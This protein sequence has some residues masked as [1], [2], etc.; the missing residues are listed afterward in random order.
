MWEITNG[1]KLD[2]DQE[3]AAQFALSRPRGGCGLWLET[4]MG[5]GFI[6]AWC[7]VEW[8][9]QK[10]ITRVLV[11][12]PA[13]L[14]ADWKMK[15]RLYANLDAYEWDD[16]PQ[17]IAAV[18]IIS[19]NLLQEPKRGAKTNRRNRVPEIVEWCPQVVIVDEAHKMKSYKAA[20]TKGLTKI[21]HACGPIKRLALT[22]TPTTT[23]DPEELRPQLTFI[24]ETLLENFGVNDWHS[25]RVRFSDVKKQRFGQVVIDQ[26]VGVK[27]QP[28]L[29]RILSEVTLKQDASSLK[30]ESRFTETFFG[31]S[32]KAQRLYQK[33]IVDGAILTKEMEIV[34]ANPLD[35]ALK[36]AEIRS[37]FIKDFAGKIHDIDTK[38]IDTVVELVS[39]TPL[40]V[41]VTYNFRHTGDRLEVALSKYRVGHIR[42]G[43]SAD[44]KSRI[45]QDFQAGKYD[46]VLGQHDAICLGLTFT[47]G[48]HIIIAE[49]TFKL[50][51]WIQELGRINR[52]GQTK[53]CFYN[54]LIEPNTLDVANYLA[55]D[56]KSD[57]ATL[58]T[59][60]ILQLAA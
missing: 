8:L 49:P 33:M 46:I 35:R 26:V 25:W 48:N 43:I 53:C 56:N 9:K 34:S 51:S 57:F 45:E 23:I 42:G 30:Q 17:H 5:K 14:V 52:R 12:V 2:P 27:N 40:P 58:I 54:K 50:E 28:M 10:G 31:M 15:L 41:L 11:A 21:L 29:D 7:L 47:R 32:A 60:G 3:I 39:D 6:G 19:H 22:A 16:D 36:C 59:S 13:G 24:D 18:Q 44:E 20:Q 37:G 4:G 38:L 1:F 55:L